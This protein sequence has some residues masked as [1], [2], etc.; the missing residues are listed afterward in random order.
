MVNEDKTKITINGVELSIGDKFTIDNTGYTLK[1]I[2]IGKS[3]KYSLRTDSKTI[4]I[5]DK[6][7]TGKT[8]IVR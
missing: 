7:I 6:F 5:G 1:E 2:Y 3:G 8:K 4:R